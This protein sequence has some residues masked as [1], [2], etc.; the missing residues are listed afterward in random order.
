[1]K[2]SCAP[3]KFCKIKKQKGGTEKKKTKKTTKQAQRTPKE[4]NE[5]FMRVLHKTYNRLERYRKKRETG[6]LTDEDLK[7]R[8]RDMLT[9]MNTANN[10]TLK[11]GKKKIRKTRKIKKK[12]KG[13]NVNQCLDD[14]INSEDPVT[15]EE[16]K[17]L[18]VDNLIKFKV[19][20]PTE[21]NKKIN[22]CYDKET[23]K[24]HI[25]AK[26][27]ADIRLDEIR[28]PLSNKV[29]GEEFIRTNFPEYIDDEDEDNDE[30]PEG[31]IE[32]IDT[33]LEL[34]NIEDN[35]LQNI[36]LEENE[37][38]YETLIEEFAQ[39]L[40]RTVRH[41]SNN[42][43]TQGM[44]DEF[45][46]RVNE[47]I[48]EMIDS[49]NKKMQLENVVQGVREDLDRGEIAGG[50]KKKRFLY[51][52][53]NP[54]KSFDVYIDKNPDD[55]IPIKYT[56]VKDVEATIKKLERLYKQGKYPHKRIW[57]VG[58]IM[59]VRLEAMKKHK[60]E[61]YPNAKNVTKRYN[62]SNRY[63]KFL[64]K[65]SKTQKNKRKKMTFTIRNKK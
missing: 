28:D 27:R 31:H 61:K 50:S 12:Q 8:D 62:L 26:L 57:Q 18:K 51:N 52:P 43:M 56:T 40:N 3:F 64:G 49:P 6:W 36:N 46:E 9:A 32:Y 42:D 19:R 14:C 21:E 20:E 22:N 44:S 17:D 63:F 16:I 54:K 5:D 4:K 25:D 35:W 24:S 7:I 45:L 41:L 23:L 30:D 13:G 1:M 2:S 38:D 65:R 48:E 55:T 39:Y 58:M 37:T 15:L 29:L 59:K 11:G 60:K 53:N 33:E 34:E 47:K 10:A